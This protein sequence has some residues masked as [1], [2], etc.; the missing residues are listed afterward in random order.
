MKNNVDLIRMDEDSSLA[1]TKKEFKLAI[2]KGELDNL[3]RQK[4]NRKIFGLSRMYLGFYNMINENKM[5]RDIEKKKV[6][7]DNKNAKRLAKGKNEKEYKNPW[8]AWFALEI[9]ELPVIYDSTMSKQ[10]VL[11]IE[12]YLYNKGF[13]NPNVKYEIK[14]DSSKRRVYVDYIIAPEIPYRINKMDFFIQNKEIK[15]LM[16]RRLTDKDSLIHHGDRFDLNDLQKFQREV[17][18]RIRDEGY[19]LFNTSMVYF[20]ADTNLLSHQVNL[21]LF[22]NDHRIVKNNENDSIISSYYKKFYI[23]NIYINT[24]FPAIKTDENEVIPYDTLS[25][26]H[27]KILY[28]HRF[29]YNP[30]LFQRALLLRKDSLYSVNDTELTF[31]KLFELGSFD[32]VNV[33]YNPSEV[34]DESKELAPLDAFINLNPAKNQ[35]VSFETTT[36]NNGGNLGISGSISYSHKNIFKG[37]EQLRISLSGGIEAQQAIDAPSTD[38]YF[39]TIEVSPE[40]ELI[41]PHFVSPFSYTKFSRILNPKTSIAIN[42]NYQNR[43][44]YTRTTTSAYYSYK[45]NS[46][47]VLYHTLN[48]FQISFTDI[49]KE[50]FFQK[51]L[52]ELNNAVL[53]A[54]YTDNVV[55]SMRYIGTFNNQSNTFQP[56]V[57][58]TRFL[59][60]EA[61]IG[62]VLIA[63][64]AGAEQDSL[65]RYLFKDIPIANFIKTEVDFRSYYNFDANNAIAYR[66]DMGVA[67]TLKNLDVIPFTDA[68]FVGGS[69]SNRAWRSRTLGPGS[70]YDTTGVEAYDKIGEIKIDLSVEY[71]FNLVSIIDMAFFIDGSN[72]WY[73]QR[74]DVSPDDPA[75]FNINRF[76]SEI[77]V[78]AGFGVRLNFNFFLIRF[79]F[80]YQAKDPSAPLGERWFWESKTKYDARVKIINEINGNNRLKLY[81]QTERVIFNLAIGYPF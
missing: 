31:K 61:G 45:W 40:I 47:K 1:P 77:A 66:I 3:V 10:S 64:A 67:W 79:D 37:A 41:F 35:T 19:Y 81:D 32:L 43:P 59:L 33:S 63:E 52:D 54:S 70:T 22:I 55:P 71:R 73:R 57:F 16:R 9:G 49:D 26:Q 15:D 13:F 65:G 27:K 30:K 62:S 75:V 44:D 74:P 2:D 50:P 51:Y 8:R 34:I 6:K 4:T 23:E 46:S 72:I 69:N 78:G 14:K 5:Q 80:G 28:Q 24:S 58:Y 60:Q 36:T 76:V 53:E 12:N 56:L 29:R 21:S 39:N 18:R 7:T 42:Y 48:I 25:Y 17:T 38:Q 11:Q 20:Q 68:F